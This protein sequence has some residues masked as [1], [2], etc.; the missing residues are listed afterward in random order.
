[1][2]NGMEKD[3][4]NYKSI[5]GNPDDNVYHEMVNLYSDIFD[6]ADEV[7]FKQRIKEHSKLVSILAYYG[8]GLI[9][10]KIGYPYNEDTFYSWV[11]G[12]LPKHRNQGIAKQLAFLQ[13]QHAKRQGFS[14]LR[15]KSMNRFRTMMILN[16]K[17]GFDI[18]KVYTNTKGQ[19]KIVFEKIIG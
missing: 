11:G 17:N 19:T 9:G 4:V 7:F 14:K 12:V 2:P 16:L 3:K 8:N 6:D 15:T 13:E 18:T 5:N 1:M 10:L